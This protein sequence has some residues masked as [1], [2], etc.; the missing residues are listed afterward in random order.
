M[1]ATLLF[2][3]LFPFVGYSQEEPGYDELMIY[4][5]VGDMGGADLPAL[6]YDEEVYLSVTDVFD[7]LR[8][9]NIPENDMHQVS[10]FFIN[11]HHTYV[12]DAKQKHIRYRNV[13]YDL[14]PD[15]VICTPTGLYLKCGVFGQV[16]ELNCKFCFRS[17]SVNVE[18]EL[19]LPVIR[20]RKLQKL[21]DNLA[22]LKG[23]APVDT[24]ILRK[25][26]LFNLGM[27]D[28]GITSSQTINGS[29]DTRYSLALGSVVAGG[30]TSLCL[31]HSTLQPF[32]LRNQR[33]L[34]HIVNNENRFLRQVHAG[35]IPNRTIVTLYSPVVGFKLSNTSTISRKSFGTYTVSDYTK[36]GWLVE[37]YI[38]SKLVNFVK[39]DAAGFYSFEVPLVY[40]SSAVELRFY[41][42]WG[43]E[44][45][46]RKDISIPMNFLP[47]GE[48]EYTLSG[49]FVQ[50]EANSTFSKVHV[51]YGLSR[52]L[53]LGSGV[54]YLTSFRTRTSIPFVEMS[55][56]LGSRILISG[57]YAHGVRTKGVLN[58]KGPLNARLN[59]D[60]ARFVKGQ[61]AIATSYQEERKLRLSLPLRMRK[62]IFYSQVN[63]SQ[64]VNARSKLTMVQQVVSGSIYGVGINLGT[65]AVFPTVS[66]PD[67]G[68]S[69]SIGYTPL[70][71]LTVTPQVRYSY[72][73]NKVVN[74][75]CALGYRLFKQGYLSVSYSRGVRT[76]E[77]TF[78]FG[79]SHDFSFA[80]TRVS[81]SHRKGVFRFTQSAN[82]SLMYDKQMN[83]TRTDSRNRVGKGGITFLAFLDYNNNKVRDDGEPKAYG[84]NLRIDGVYAHLN[85]KDTTVRAYDMI[86]YRNYVVHLDPSSFDNIAW[87]IKKKT[88][89][90]TP[91]SNQ[92]ELV[93][94]PVAIMGEVAGMV[95]PGNENEVKGL[96]RIMIGFYDSNNQLV[97]QTLSES[98]GYFSYFGLPT[99][100]YTA[101]IDAIQMEKL[102][103]I[104]SPDYLSFTIKEIEEGDYVDGLEFV[105]TDLMDT[106]KMN[107]ESMLIKKNAETTTVV[108][109]TIVETDGMKGNEGPLLKDPIN[110]D[111]QL[112]GEKSEKTFGDKPEVGLVIDYSQEQMF[113]AHPFGLPIDENE[114]S[115]ILKE[116]QFFI[117][118]TLLV[119]NQQNSITNYPKEE[120]SCY[121]KWLE[122][123]VNLI[124]EF[125]DKILMLDVFRE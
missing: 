27:A 43:E 60:Y 31:N 4:L 81:A 59:L 124:N 29:V 79:F 83:F 21:R 67:I 52:S 3:L 5:K 63:L 88:L 100:T 66:E 38:N 90:V 62:Q 109:S 69:L 98:D 108:D 117:P 50:D 10:G 13:V 6:F 74:M 34:W 54:E 49:G 123:L 24:V 15:D 61:T 51:N 36:P 101:R 26:P 102:K 14:Q 89:R 47:A 91:I 115:S 75:N 122:F 16:F 39:A 86:P 41:G 57:E 20:E 68:S 48:L 77:N 12:I 44:Y 95:M 87:R 116:E 118:D 23:E 40:G 70:H 84:L 78:S 1:H 110:Q 71:G 33:Y 113:D 114:Y 30:A 125:I 37:L 64:F 2:L 9:K 25:Y 28:W 53:T 17:L 85:E 73:D 80:R 106:V 92:F 104:V 93:E 19:E 11:E 35:M 105:I 119:N 18:T 32:S 56:Q 99:G 107:P 7:L 103:M 8:I 45:T 82:G 46:T 42:P 121:K 55:L 120:M 97:S 76:G 111:G 58:C 72:S 65:S 96:G 22:M 94:I 112:T